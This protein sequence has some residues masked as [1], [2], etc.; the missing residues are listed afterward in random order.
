MG[1]L[2]E[3]YP[4]EQQR[5]R[6][7]LQGYRDIGPAGSFG[8]RAIEEVLQRADEAVGR[9]DLVRM[10]R[11]L[12][13]MQACVMR[14]DVMKIERR[15]KWGRDLICRVV[16]HQEEFHSQRCP[17]AGTE[18]VYARLTL[19]GGGEAVGVTATVYLPGYTA[20]R[21]CGLFLRHGR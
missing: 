21:R 17:V 7:V 8:A 12:K 4:V 15:A 10:I 6:G 14:G 13:E 3:Q 19:A 11:S 1:S 2:G 18:T 5:C 16:G 9:Q 20:C